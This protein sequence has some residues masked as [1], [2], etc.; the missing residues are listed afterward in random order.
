MI[1]L[2]CQTALIDAGSVR[3]QLK[4][5]AFPSTLASSPPG[6]VD[7]KR[8]DQVQHCWEPFQFLCHRSHA[9]QL[10]LGQVESLL[11]SEA[12]NRSRHLRIE[13]IKRLQRQRGKRRARQP[14]QSTQARGWNDL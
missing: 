14:R 9:N 10:D 13:R 3:L 6:H 2:A 12:S 11:C 1:E 7:R 5:A 4:N 8:I